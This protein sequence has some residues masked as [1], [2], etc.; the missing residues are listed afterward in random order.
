VGRSKYP[1]R[2]LGLEPNRYR[3]TRVWYR[4]LE[5]LVRYISR[6]PRSDRGKRKKE[7]HG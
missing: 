6:K 3:R 2:V 5:E 4:Q 7:E 1:G